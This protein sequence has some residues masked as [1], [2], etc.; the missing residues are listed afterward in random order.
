MSYLIT[1]L[2]L[3]AALL[4]FTLGTAG[5]GFAQIAGQPSEVTAIYA[6]KTLTDPDARLACYDTAVGRLEVAQKSGEIVTLS[7]TQV[8]KV[9]KDAFGFNIP[10]LPGL[11]KLFG[12][13]SKNKPKSKTH[14]A[15][16]DM[17]ALADIDAPQSKPKTKKDKAKK[18]KTKKDKAKKK[19]AAIDADNI[20]SVSLTLRKTTTF[21][22]KKTRFFFNN[23]Q[24]WEQADSLSVR[25]PKS[26]GGIPNTAKITKAAL[27]S[28]MLRVN[29]KG[30]AVRVRR[31]R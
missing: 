14:A 13:G 2:Y 8:E 22:H 9:K 19:Q 18:A 3:V 27:G 23:G 10:S 4:V 17:P 28:Y 30:R 29:G 25:I 24:V 11:G 21:G 15:L 7:K 16:A 31:V 1:R 5:V 6:C 12:G 26:R 20:K